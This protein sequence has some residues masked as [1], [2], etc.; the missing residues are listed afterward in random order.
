[1]EQ[2]GKKFEVIKKFIEDIDPEELLACVQSLEKRSEQIGWGKN[3]DI[4]A[5]GDKNYRMLCAKKLKPKPYLIDNRPEEEFKYQEMV[6]E[7]G[8]RTPFS[9]AMI[10]N[11][12]TKEEYIIMERIMGVSV[13]DVV[14]NNAPIPEAYNHELFFEKLERDLKKMHEDGIYHRDLHVGNVMIDENGNPVIIDFGSATIAFSG[15]EDKYVQTQVKKYNSF[16]DRY[17]VVSGRYLDDDDGFESIK[18]SMTSVVY[19]KAYKIDK[20][21][22]L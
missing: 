17:E 6:R 3:A 9:I 12:E 11:I 18:S 7:L 1:M 8:V 10:R 16:T 22:E 2:M 19:P 13:G 14:K 5:V 21:W 15:D 20:P 4:L